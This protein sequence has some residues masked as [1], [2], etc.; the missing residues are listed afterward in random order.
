M[1]WPRRVCQWWRIDAL[2][3]HGRI[4]A[5][6]D[7]FGDE[8]AAI[9]RAAPISAEVTRE[10]HGGVLFLRTSCLYLLPVEYRECPCLDATCVR[11]LV[12]YRKCLAVLGDCAANLADRFASPF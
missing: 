1:N 8:Q 7:G 3:R 10:P 11:Y 5:A 2:I 4:R 6:G 9:G 12:I